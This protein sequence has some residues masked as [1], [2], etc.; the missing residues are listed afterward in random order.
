[1]TQAKIKSAFK[2]TGSTTK[3]AKYNRA[4]IT[5]VYFN[6]H[7]QAVGRILLVSLSTAILTAVPQL[8]DG[9]GT[10]GAQVQS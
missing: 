3:H 2:G 5:H 7:Q 8:V 9:S 6:V 10:Q 1:M 4:N